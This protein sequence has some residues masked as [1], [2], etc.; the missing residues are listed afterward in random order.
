LGIAVVEA[1]ACGVPVVISN[2]VNIWREVVQARAGLVVNCDAHEV[3]QAL[4]SLLEAPALGKDMGERGRQLVEARFT[5]EV[6][7]EQMAQVYRQILSRP[8]L[9]SNGVDAVE[10]WS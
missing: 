8:C 6:V 4:V 5:W 9:H 7:G 3:G 2:K 10:S 1:M